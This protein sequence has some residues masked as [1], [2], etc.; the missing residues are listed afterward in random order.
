LDPAPAAAIGS[1]NAAFAAMWGAAMAGGA[2]Q[3]AS[4]AAGQ[5]AAPAAAISAAAVQLAGV[6]LGGSSVP[7]ADLPAAAVAA[8]AAGPSIQ[9]LPP[10]PA[11]GRDSGDISPPFGSGGPFG[12][13]QGLSLGQAD[14]DEPEA[15]TPHSRSP[16]AGGSGSGGLGCAKVSRWALA[17][18]LNHEP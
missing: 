3:P 11:G 10:L 9:P 17:S 12:A 2:P 4:T 15:A 13:V 6:R 16:L 1:S 8:A 5:P 14:S 18:A 7:Q